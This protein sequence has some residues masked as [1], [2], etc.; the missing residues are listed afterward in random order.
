M[1]LFPRIFRNFAILGSLT[2]KAAAQK[3]FFMLFD[4]VIGQEEVKLL[5][6]RM[7]QEGRVP[8]A[9]LFAGPSGSGKL[10]MALTLARS[11][12][13]RSRA[14]DGS[15]CGQCAS[16]KMAAALAHPDLHFVFPVFKPAGQSTPAVS[17]NF[18]TQWRQQLSETPYFTC[19][20]W[21]KRIGVE[22]QQSI[23]NVAEANLILTKLSTVSSQGGYRVIVMW[24]ADRLNAEAANKL[25]KILEEPPA[26]TVF[27]L[28][29]D[30]PEKILPTILSRTQRVE[31]RPL[32]E[33]RIAEAL[34]G[35]AGLQP[36]DAQKVARAS[37]GSFTKALEQVTLN[38]D[39]AQFFDHF[40]LLMRLCYMR[41]VKELQDW[42][43]QVAQWGRE[44][45]KAFLAYAMRMVRENFVRNFGLPQLNYMNE[46][47]DAFS[48]KFARFINE[49]NVIPISEELEKAQRDIEQNVNAR[50][51]FFDLAL[52][53]IVLLIQ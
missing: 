12:L 28:T 2:E 50:M 1:F 5:L 35:A 16:C 24:Q 45:Q 48:A 27:V 51:V 44:K 26:H 41:K 43:M 17:D 19:Q 36:Q 39:A 3:G 15:P 9:L 21:L 31:F 40:V 23:I 14:A 8:H 32:T 52:K 46:E 20:T 30:T 10:A 13:C 11:L 6:Q 29:T 49:R 7:L 34:Q 22:N 42:A 18:L 33:E 53:I 37:A 38:A 4:D 25:L 47:E